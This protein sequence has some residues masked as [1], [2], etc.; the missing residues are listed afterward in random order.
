[1][2]EKFEKL[3]E[4]L[5]RNNMQPFFAENK[6][7]ALRIVKSLIKKGES[8]AAGGSMTLEEC[9]ITEL[10]RNGDYVFFDRSVAETPEESIEIMKKAY[11]ADNYFCSSNAVTEDGFLFN[12]DGNSNRVSAI[13]YGPKSVI[14]VVGKNKIVKDLNEA[15]L[16]VKKIAAPRNAVRLDCETY[17][18]HTGE[19]VSLKNGCPGITDGCVSEDRICRNYVICGPQRCKNRIKIILV[20]EDIGY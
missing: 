5:K 17:C 8:A 6:E 12:V 2:T 11:N 16:R 3:A 13:L 10:L 20:N 15:Q 7:E 14:M 9:K 19:C 1:M 4:A 18:K